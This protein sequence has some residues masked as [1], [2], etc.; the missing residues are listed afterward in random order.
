[1]VVGLSL[2]TI[3]VHSRGRIISIV[4]AVLIF[5]RELPVLVLEISFN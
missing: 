3:M 5:S 2:K 1:M 4:G